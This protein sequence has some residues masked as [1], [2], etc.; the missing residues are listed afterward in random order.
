MSINTV[1]R[2]EWIENAI[3]EKLFKRYDYEKFINFQKVGAGAFGVVHRVNC[4]D[5]DQHYALKS[6]HEYDNNTLDAIVHE[7]MQV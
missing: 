2:D 4:V 5:C 3:N 1:R 6:F 7:V